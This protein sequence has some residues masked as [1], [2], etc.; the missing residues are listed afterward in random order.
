MSV[1]CMLLS[2]VCFIVQLAVRAIGLN[3]RD[4]L[5]C[6]GMYPGDPGP[7]GGDCAG[8]VLVVGPGAERPHDSAHGSFM[9]Y[10]MSQPTCAIG[11]CAEHAAG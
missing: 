10:S 8:T 7:P 5:N 2:V 9:R 3:F 4:V 6:L 1:S 11:L